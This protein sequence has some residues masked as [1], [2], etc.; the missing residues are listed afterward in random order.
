MVKRETK[1]WLSYS[2]CQQ[3]T[4]DILETEKIRG[5]LKT[6]GLSA[7]WPRQLK[8]PLFEVWLEPKQPM[9]DDT[10][11]DFIPVRFTCFSQ[12]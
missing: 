3:K 2:L 1:P 12:F 6:A 7:I 10:A 9:E 11:G 4:F 8:L 5:K